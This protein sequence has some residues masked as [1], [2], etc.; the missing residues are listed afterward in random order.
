MRN[1]IDTAVSY[2]Y[3]FSYRGEKIQSENIN[4]KGSL[5]DFVL[6][7]V[8]GVTSIVNYYNSWIKFSKKEKVLFLKYEK[9]KNKTELIL[10]EISDNLNIEIIDKIVSDSVLF[11]IR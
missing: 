2:Y 3:H 8:G 4:F 10:K 1:P 9:L 6:G 11:V 5:D 7:S